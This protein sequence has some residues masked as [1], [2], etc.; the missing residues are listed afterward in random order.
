M[1]FIYSGKIVTHVFSSNI[2]IALFAAIAPPS[3]PVSTFKLTKSLPY[4]GGFISSPPHTLNLEYGSSEPLTKPSAASNP[5]QSST[6][7]ALSWAANH[8]G[9]KNL[10]ASRSGEAEP[11]EDNL[12]VS[13][14][15]P[16]NSSL[17]TLKFPTPFPISPLLLR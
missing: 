17:R 2:L 4:I 15:P 16:D 11:P 3:S 14:A 13:V 1:G 5:L 9:A 10:I 6:V 8:F 12:S 7:T